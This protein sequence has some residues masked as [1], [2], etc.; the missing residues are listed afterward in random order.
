MKK[1]MV[2]IALVGFTTFSFAATPAAPAAKQQTTVNA[3]TKTACQKTKKCCAKKCCANNACAK[4]AN[5]AN[6]TVSVKK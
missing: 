3:K 1:L 2:I 4:K 5:T 6:K